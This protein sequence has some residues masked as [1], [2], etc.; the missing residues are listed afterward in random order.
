MDGLSEGGLAGSSESQSLFCALWLSKVSLC[1][2]KVWCCCCLGLDFPKAQEAGAP[3]VAPW[4]TF[5]E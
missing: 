2:W 5:R 1:I 3:P 4:A